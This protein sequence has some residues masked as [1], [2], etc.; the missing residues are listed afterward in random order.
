MGER[1]VLFAVILPLHEICTCID[2]SKSAFGKYFCVS[3][4]VVFVFR[5]H[6]SSVTGPVAYQTIRQNRF[7]VKVLNDNVAFPSLEVGIPIV[8]CIYCTL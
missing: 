7:F 1:F 8:Y 4:C 6:H 2:C 5:V 3:I